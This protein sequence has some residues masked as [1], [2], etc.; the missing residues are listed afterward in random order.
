MRAS[1]ST[2]EWQSTFREGIDNVVD[3]ADQAL[4]LRERATGATG[5][6]LRRATERSPLP[7]RGHQTLGRSTRSPSTTLLGRLMMRAVMGDRRS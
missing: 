5:L 2:N 4:F 3:L 1:A 7:F 6:Q